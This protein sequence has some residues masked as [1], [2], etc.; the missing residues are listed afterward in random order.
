[1]RIARL[2]VLVGCCSAIAAAPAPVDVAAEIG[3]LA[4]PDQAVRDAAARRIRTAIAANPRAA[5]DHDAAF[6]RARLAVVKPGWSKAQFEAAVGA[7]PWGTVGSGQTETVSWRLDDYWT[8]VTYFDD[9]SGFRELGPIQRDPR[10]VWAD[11][12]K[13]FSGRWVTY[14]VTGAMAHA[15]AYDHGAY[16][17]FDSYYPNGQLVYRQNYVAGKINGAEVGYHQN[18]AKA[19]VGQH[20]AGTRVGHWTHWYP[21]G[22][23]ETEA[24]YDAAGQL[25]GNYVLNRPDGTSQVLFEYAHG[26]ETGQAAW[27]EHGALQ[28]AHGTTAAHVH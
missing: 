3:R 11:P 6:W 10:Q 14:F 9:R 7:R 21:D 5:G 19:Y 24:E 26:K 18:G 2:A 27:D 25:D 28:Y 22:K 20:A 16:V 17:T 13:G 1:M 23:I 4:S 15:I 8:V 12:P